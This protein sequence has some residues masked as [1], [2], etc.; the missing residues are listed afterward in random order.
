MFTV[1]A[2]D[3]KFYQTYSPFWK[4]RIMATESV[5]ANFM[6]GISKRANVITKQEDFVTKQKELF[7]NRND[8][9]TKRNEAVSK[10]NDIC[11]KCNEAV[12]NRDDIVTKCNEAVSNRNDTFLFCVPGYRNCPI[13]FQPFYIQRNINV[14]IIYK[15]F[16]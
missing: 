7:T 4:G 2:F 9:C 8:I 10:C 16:T 1:F 13:S 12:S 15:T 14:S 3:R 11:T 6:T 5:P